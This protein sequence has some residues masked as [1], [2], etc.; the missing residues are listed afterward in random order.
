MG[1]LEAPAPRPT[2]VSATY[3]YSIPELTI[4]KTYPRVGP[5][6]QLSYFESLKQQEPVIAFDPAEL[7][8]EADWVRAGALVFRTTLNPSRSPASVG[9]AL[10]TP[11]SR[12]ERAHI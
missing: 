7:Q 5:D 4:Y 10:A 1:S 2:H 8:T 6:K 9:A 3:Y 12:L 11:S